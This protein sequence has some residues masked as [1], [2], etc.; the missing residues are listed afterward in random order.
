MMVVIKASMSDPSSRMIHEKKKRREKLTK[1][2]QDT[3][4]GRPSVTMFLRLLCYT[5]HARSS[6]IKHTAFIANLLRWMDAHT[7]DT[8]VGRRP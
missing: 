6:R 3:Q 4:N 7:Q 1:P 8:R 2:R 5:A